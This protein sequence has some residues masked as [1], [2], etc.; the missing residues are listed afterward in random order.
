MSGWPQATT[1][2][3]WASSRGRQE[4]WPYEK[5]NPHR[6]VDGSSSKR[7]AT[8]CT[9]A[10][11][12]RRCWSQNPARAGATTR[13]VSRPGIVVAV[14]SDIIGSSTSSE[15]RTT[16]RV[17]WSESSMIRTEALTLRWFSTRT[18]NGGTSWRRG[19]VKPVIR[20]SQGVMRRSDP[21]TPC[22]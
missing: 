1:S 16:S 7:F 21:A 3:S 8:T 12:M 17:A 9:R 4:L 18:V 5:R 22:L 14:T 13:D 20:Y 2:T 10:S 19:A 15:T 6:Q 11:P